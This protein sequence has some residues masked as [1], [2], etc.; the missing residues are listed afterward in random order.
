[1]DTATLD[2]HFPRYTDHDPLVAVWCLTPELGGCFHRFF[3]TPPVNPS[4]EI[5][6]LTRMPFEDRIPDPGEAAEIVL[7][8]LS[9]GQTR[10]LA[11]TRGWEP[12]LG[13]NVN[14]LDEKTLVFNDVE[15]GE[16]QPFAV[17]VDVE[18]GEKIRLGGTVYQA[19]PDGRWLASSCMK[20][21]RWTQAGY[22]V[23]VPDEEVQANLGVRDDD[24]LTLTDTQ[25]GEA[26]LQLSLKQI[27]EQAGP[28]ELRDRPDD[29]QV[30]GFHVKW[31]PQGDRLL[32]T[33]R[34][35]EKG[36]RQLE[37]SSMT[38]GLRFAVYTLKPDGTDLHLA[39]HPD[40]WVKGGH[41]VNF[42]PD[43]RS[44][45]TNLVMDE[46]MSLVGCALDGSDC[47]RILDGPADEVPIG[48]GHPSVHPDGRHIL[49]DA[50]TFESFSFGD[51]T[52]PLRW[53]DRR[54][55]TEQ[56]AVRIST[57]SPHESTFRTL[58]VDPHPA[59]DR[60]WRW[61]FFNGFVNGTRR[62]YV[63]DFAPL[64]E[65]SS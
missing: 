60:S 62:V 61:V 3:D 49:T 19:S 17:K 32:Y 35:F 56:V 11:E 6:A 65:R 1:M 51:G 28:D 21:M 42:F 41:H 63:A 46:V 14:W 44:L 23:V 37:K 16:W 8:D 2:Q 30:H 40:Q 31:N 52:V 54:T 39:L 7:V 18:T 55:K 36:Q 45:S 29:F 27:V 38:P 24:G 12:Q 5:V 48:S 34:W 50:Y 26:K 64:L 4:G 10:V 59:W 20:R 33:L 25:T 58:R 15:P 13:A 43:G 22:G 9:T 57:E 53:I 47:R